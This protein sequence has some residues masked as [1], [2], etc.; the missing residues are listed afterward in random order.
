MYVP[1]AACQPDRRRRLEGD[2]NELGL[3]QRSDGRPR[4]LDRRPPE[5]GASLRLK[6]IVP[7]F[8][9]QTRIW[10]TEGASSSELDR[11]AS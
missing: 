7:S 5:E 11:S 6:R 1:E 3:A 10:P 4:A 8:S 9:K 2:Q